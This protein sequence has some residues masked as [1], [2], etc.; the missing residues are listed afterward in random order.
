METR[1]ATKQ[2]ELEQHIGNLTALMELKVGQDE[3]ARHQEVQQTKLFDDLRSL[4]AR[5]SS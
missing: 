1:S 5:E 3:Q 4:S 2:Q